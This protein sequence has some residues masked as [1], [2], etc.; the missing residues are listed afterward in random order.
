MLQHPCTDFQLPRFLRSQTIFGLSMPVL[1]CR[2][3]A[4]Y[5]IE[6]FQRTPLL[7]G[8]SVTALGANCD[9]QFLQWESLSL[10]EQEK[11]NGLMVRL[12]LSLH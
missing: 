4:Y 9:T 2:L 10:A 11:K 6:V 1:P 8:G 12:K 5:L 7:M 3:L